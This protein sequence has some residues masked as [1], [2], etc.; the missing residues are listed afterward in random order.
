MCEE[1]FLCDEAVEVLCKKVPQ[2]VPKLVGTQ[3]PT[4]GGLSVVGE[5][6]LGGTQM[7]SE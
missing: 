6:Q 7:Q 1:L 4:P 5:N 3:N 2:A